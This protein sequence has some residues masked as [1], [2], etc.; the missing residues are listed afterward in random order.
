VF[1]LGGAIIPTLLHDGC[2][3]ISKCI[4]APIKLTAYMDMYG[5]SEGEVYFDDGISNDY[6]TGGYEKISYDWSESRLTVSSTEGSWDSGKVVD[7]IVI[8]GYGGLGPIAV[9]QGGYSTEWTFV[10]G[11][12]TVKLDS[13]SVRDINLVVTMMCAE[14]P[15]E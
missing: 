6:Q 4:D 7:E 3:A 12:L 14:E 2:L 13:V 9:T 1:I 5:H 15:E 10:P 11:T 8:H